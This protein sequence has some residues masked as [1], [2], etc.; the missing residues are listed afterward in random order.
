MGYGVRRFFHKCTSPQ[1][2]NLYILFFAATI[3][4]LAHAT[5]AALLRRVPGTNE[6]EIKIFGHPS[7]FATPVLTATFFVVHFNRLVV[8]SWLTLFRVRGFDPVGWCDKPGYRGF[9]GCWQLDIGAHPQLRISTAHS[10]AAITMQ[11][12]SLWAKTQGRVRSQLLTCLCINIDQG[13]NRNDQWQECYSYITSI[14]AE[15]FTRRCDGFD[16][17]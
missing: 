6:L 9:S 15:R 12:I 17:E 5:R 14:R 3:A 11:Q 4:R 7:L 13:R 16:Q 10:V 2:R 1:Y 8:P